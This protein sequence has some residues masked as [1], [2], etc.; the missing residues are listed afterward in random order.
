MNRTLIS[1][2]IACI[3]ALAAPA[4]SAQLTLRGR[5]VDADSL[6]LPG[7]NVAI[8]SQ[9]SALITGTT[10]GNDGHFIIKGIPSG[11]YI[12]SATMIGYDNNV[13]PISLRT[14]LDLSTIMFSESQNLLNEV[15][16][17][18]EI[19]RTFANRDELLLP[20]EVKKNSQNAVD[21]IAQMPKF[22]KSLNGKLSTIDG[23][24]LLIVIDGRKATDEDLAA[25]P[26]DNIKKLIHYTTPPARYMEENVSSVLEV[27]TKKRTG[28]TYELTLNTTNG[29]L[30]ANGQNILTAVY[31]DSVN[32][33][34]ASYRIDYQ[35]FRHGETENI[36][37]Y[38]DGG[39]WSENRYTSSN[40]TSCYIRQ[41][42]VLDYSLTKE[43]YM[44]AAEASYRHA[45]H[46][47]TTPQDVLLSLPD[48]TA[49]SGTGSSLV[50]NMEQT[51][52]LDLY[53]SLRLRNSQELLFN[54][55]NTYSMSE[56]DN[57]LSRTIADDPSRNYSLRNLYDNSTY[58]LIAQ[59][60]YATPLWGGQF[61]VSGRFEHK[62]L[63][64]LYN[65][66]MRTRLNYQTEYL[67]LSWTK[68]WNRWNLYAWLSAQNLTFNGPTHY[69]F[70][71][72]LPVAIVSYSP[73]D[74]ITLKLHAGGATN[75]PKVGDLAGSV[76]SIDDRYTS[77]GNST[78]RP[79]YGYQAMLSMDL[80]NKANTL[81]FSPFIKY[82]Y[83]KD[84]HSSMLYR[85]A[86]GLF[87]KQTRQA[88][89]PV[90]IQM[91]ASLQWRPVK[92]F[93]LLGSAF[94]CYNEYY[95][96][97]NGLM[98]RWWGNQTLGARFNVWELQAE[99]LCFNPFGQYL[100]RSDNGDFISH[101]VPSYRATLAWTHR[102]LKVG[103]GYLHDPGSSVTAA[104][105]DMTV[106]ESTRWREMR[107]F[108]FLDFSYRFRYGDAHRRTV[109]KRLNNEDTDTGL[110]DDM[111]AR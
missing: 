35:D 23:G 99:F 5:Y 2:L 68:R 21:A 13:R 59:V 104:I 77:V 91:Y 87:Y 86:D 72:L 45:P 70:F 10:T 76:V 40:S 108:L 32:R 96:V 106:E 107:H 38:L 62:Q 95:T 92:W 65:S 46:E 11:D 29:L 36:Y 1:T 57:A 111:R 51:A 26:P 49:L 15:V 56:A 60:T 7:V 44:F 43:R 25:I 41:D 69:N 71:N 105:S 94:A 88:D 19:R 83:A 64:Q 78:L 20:Q 90:S 84:Y 67:T 98:R 3:L 17:M 85:G 24:G 73:T 27:V 97:S 102:D 81:F 50:S 47:N 18:S 30:S 80:K 75:M 34:S 52:A 48:G 55:V 53:L 37:R 63:D 33:I 14:D 42:A 12:L 93:T 54:V 61:E 79:F 6:A 16:V 100:D 9:D 28:R 103:L 110:T 22:S 74:L 39:S 31:A 58:S 8:L 89:N 66:S 109:Q 82:W 101:T 4:A